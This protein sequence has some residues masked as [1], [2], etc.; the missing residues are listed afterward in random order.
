MLPRSK[1][2]YI[3]YL[4]LTARSASFLLETL[5]EIKTCVPIG[6]KKKLESH[7]KK[8]KLPRRHDRTN[9]QHHDAMHL[10]RK[11]NLHESCMCVKRP[12]FC[13]FSAQTSGGLSFISLVHP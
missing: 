7:E 8:K 12:C 4:L 2:W 11:Y 13:T 3:L 1:I 10:P 6:L 5:R 9:N